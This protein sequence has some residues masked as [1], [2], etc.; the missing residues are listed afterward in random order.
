M[1]ESENN[2]EEIVNEALQFLEGTAPF[3]MSQGMNPHVYTNDA[4]NPVPYGLLDMFY[5]LVHENRVGIMVGLDAET[6][7]PAT[8]LCFIGDKD[9]ENVELFPVAKLIQAEETQ[10]YRAPIGNG[11]F[12]EPDASDE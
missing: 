8:M 12:Y 6:N 9:G 11:E 7:E 10:R 3:I 4:F 5:R 2:N 1:A